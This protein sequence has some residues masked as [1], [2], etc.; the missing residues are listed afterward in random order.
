MLKIMIKHSSFPTY[1][2]SK[3][4][5]ETTATRYHGKD[6]VVGLQSIERNPFTVKNQTL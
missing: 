1:E 3:H 5:Y 6:N 2:I 4:R